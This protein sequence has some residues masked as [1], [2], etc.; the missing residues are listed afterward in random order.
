MSTSETNMKTHMTT[1]H[2]DQCTE[3]EIKCTCK[4]KQKQH[5]QATHATHSIRIQ[6]RLCDKKFNKQDTF[7]IHMKKIHNQSTLIKL[8]KEHLIRNNEA[9]VGAK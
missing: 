9:Q 5:M 1:A 8:N 4:A 6:C 7:K 3:C 2:K